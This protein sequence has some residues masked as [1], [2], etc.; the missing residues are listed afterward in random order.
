M[1]K[2]ILTFVILSF[3]VALKITAVKKK[4]VYIHFFSVLCLFLFV[5]Y[6][7]KRKRQ[8]QGQKKDK[9]KDREKDKGEEKV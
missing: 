9:D 3:I 2:C 6:I 4:N 5:I 8:R 1:R 7:T